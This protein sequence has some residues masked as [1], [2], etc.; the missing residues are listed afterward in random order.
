MATYEEYAKAR[1]PE[2]KQEE[3]IEEAKEQQEERQISTPDVNWEK[4]YKDLEVAYSRQGQQVGDM[5][6]LI[7][8]YVTTTPDNSQQ[9]SVEVT[10]ITQEELYENPDEAVRRAV[11]S[12]PAI[13]EAKDIKAELAKDKAERMRA[14][15]KAR[16]PDCETVAASPEFA[17]WVQEDP[18][19]Q[20]LAQRGNDFDVPSADALFAL[21]DAEQAAQQVVVEDD[22][23]AVEAV[24]L[25]T[26]TGAEAPAPDRYSRSEM[27]EQKIR[28]KQG[29]QAAQR[30]VK[31]HQVTY[32]E[33]LG[34]GN[35]RD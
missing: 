4:R 6:Q 1:S 30:Y 10:P 15:F 12:H 35:V 11:E 14:E 23:A 5:R 9:D 32:R 2:V 19:R 34:A 27:L 26:G 16:H 13:Q 24:G 29:D 25:E 22:T 28:A 21:W 31:Q 7:D 8:D 3:E 33:A 17:N 18:L 20:E